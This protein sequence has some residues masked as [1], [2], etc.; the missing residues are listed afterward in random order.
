[1]SHRSVA[2]CLLLALTGAV[3][4][5][6]ICDRPEH[7]AGQLK[8]G[9]ALVH[10]FTLVNRGKE[11]MQLGEPRGSCG[12]LRPTVSV[13]TLA[14][15]E[16]TTVRVEI[17]TVTQS[18]GPNAWRM[19]VPYSMPS[20]QGETLLV[21]RADLTPELTIT[22]ASLVIHTDRSLSH[23]LKLVERRSQPL[24]VRGVATTSPFVQAKAGEPEQ[25]GG[26]WCRT[27]TLE[28]TSGCPEGRHE[29]ALVV[30]T[31]DP[32]CPELKVPFTVVKRAPEAV[33]ASPAEV[34]WTANAGPLPSRIVLLSS[35][36]D[37]PIEIDG[38]DV[39]HECL[40]VRYAAGPGSRA[41][42]RIVCE[43][44]PADG[45]HGEVRVRVKGPKPGVVSIPVHVAP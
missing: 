40:Q 44:P 10:Q 11:T 23:S 25:E 45:L 21:V 12:C 32:D 41:T 20:Q 28:V 14:P 15:G 42:L 1:V 22:P 24:M 26:S 3:R 9:V 39:S 37:K 2:V 35:G 4:A 29:H 34:S 43:Q 36:S 17:H 18:A 19:L 16:S 6:L 7:D 27:L 30:H 33:K 13:K 31:S 5:D 38:V 8:S